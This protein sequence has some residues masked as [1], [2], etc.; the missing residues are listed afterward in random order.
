MELDFAIKVLDF[1]RERLQV[2]DKIMRRAYDDA[3]KA[4]FY[5]KTF[6]EG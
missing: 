1:M 5:S 6:R 3:V 4:V 2:S